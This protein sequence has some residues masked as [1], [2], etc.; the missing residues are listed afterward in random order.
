MGKCGNIKNRIELRRR[1]FSLEEKRKISTDE[2]Y[3]Y[4]EVIEEYCSQ[5][6]RVRKMLWIKVVLLIMLIIVIVFILSVTPLGFYIRKCAEWLIIIPMFF[7]GKNLGQNKPIIDVAR[8]ARKEMQNMMIVQDVV[9]IESCFVDKKFKHN[10]KSFL[11][12]MSKRYVL[13]S[14]KD[15]VYYI[16]KKPEQQFYLGDPVLVKLIYTMKSRIVV[17]YTILKE[18][19]YNQGA[20]NELDINE[21]IERIERFTKSEWSYKDVKLPYIK[22]TYNSEFD[23]YFMVDVFFN[24]IADINNDRKI[25]LACRQIG[26]KIKLYL[27]KYDTLQIENHKEQIGKIIVNVLGNEIEQLDV[28]SVEYDYVI[29]KAEDSRKF[30]EL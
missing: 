28:K 9:N 4:N 3:K 14:N 22:F 10:Y 20:D 27:E 19:K 16:K 18:E 2:Y 24:G 8:L 21:K 6:D 7:I 11:L 23:I 17:D 13:V 12:R 30:I 29:R 26:K 1:G 15:E 5:I 25:N